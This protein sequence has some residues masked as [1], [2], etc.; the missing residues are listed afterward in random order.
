MEGLKLRSYIITGI[1]VAFSAMVYLTPRPGKVEGKDQNWMNK[2]APSVVGSYTFA[3]SEADPECSYKQPQMVYDTLAPT[4]G[5]LARGLRSKDAS[6]DV[7]LIASRDRVSFHDPRVCFTAQGYNITEESAI[8]IP[9]K[10][11]GDIPATFGK[12]TRPDKMTGI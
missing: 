4:V 3:P 7:T 9:T 1:L 5:M 6:F 11:R 10:T 2:A 8:S 12:M